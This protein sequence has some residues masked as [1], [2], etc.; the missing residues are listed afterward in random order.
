MPERHAQESCIKVSE[1]SAVGTGK[2][3]QQ[4]TSL[5]TP[6]VLCNPQESVV[7]VNEIRGLN[8]INRKHTGLEGRQ[9]QPV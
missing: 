9:D 4:D 8:G 1:S 5:Q 7:W 3:A 6:W 2:D